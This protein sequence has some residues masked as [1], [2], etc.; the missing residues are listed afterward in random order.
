MEARHADLVFR[1]WFGYKVRQRA[2]NALDGVRTMHLTR[3]SLLPAAPAPTLLVAALTS[4][5]ACNDTSPG[6]WANLTGSGNTL[7]GMI[8]VASHMYQGPD[9]NAARDFEIQFY[10]DLG[11]VRFREHF[12][13]DHVEPEN[14]VW[15]FAAVT[16][17]VAK[18]REAGLQVTAMLKSYGDFW[19]RHNDDDDTIDP[20]EYGEY[21][22]EVAREFCADV[23]EYEIWNE[24]NNFWSPQPD[25]AHYGELLK[26]AYTAIKAACP[27]ARVLYGGL[28]SYDFTNLLDRWWF[29]PAVYEAHPDICQYFDVMAVHPY[30]VAQ[31]LPPESD[32]ELGG[33]LFASQPVMT[34]WVREL[35]AVIG[36]PEKPL[37]FTEL[38]WPSYDISEQDQGRWLSRAMLLAARDGVE[39][40]LWYTF[41]DE[42]PITT[43]DRP[44]ANYFGLFGWR[45][46]DGLTRRVKPAALAMYGLAAVLGDARFAK[47]L[48]PMLGL[49]NDVY[50]LVFVAEDRIVAALWDGRDIPD[51]ADG[52]SGEGGPD[53]HFALKLPLP[54]RT[55]ATILS[56]LEGNELQRGGAATELQLDLTPAV[57]YLTIEH[58]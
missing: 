7:R 17:Q 28:D 19:A 34:K 41:W 57:Q 50:A 18:A 23:H 1:D 29:I 11:G 27:D 24:Q 45:G 43:G 21:A 51:E 48:S 30:T 42:E 40:A 31:A 58:D 20:A 5:G 38:G 15:N 4:L 37:S 26:A 3:R 6:L 55:T 47:D 8:G 22:G 53:T 36:C 49:P 12:K 16:T 10:H 9:E 13:W 52:V 35:L 56:D 39:S 25:P 33:V 14:D 2:G 46:E 54:E 44:H 32:Y